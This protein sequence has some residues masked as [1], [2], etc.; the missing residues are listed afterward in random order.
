MKCEGCE[1]CVMEA[2]PCIGYC[3]WGGPYV[4]KE[5]GPWYDDLALRTKKELY[6]TKDEAP[7]P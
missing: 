6:D 2:K 7:G 1:E 5:T 3:A 4:Y